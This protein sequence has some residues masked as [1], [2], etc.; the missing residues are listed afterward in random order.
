MEH[1]F[2]VSRVEW[3]EP[4]PGVVAEDV[5]VGEEFLRM[6]EDLLRMDETRRVKLSMCVGCGKVC[7]CVANGVNS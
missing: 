5:F 1:A 2:D 4:F 3:A 6:R 7:S